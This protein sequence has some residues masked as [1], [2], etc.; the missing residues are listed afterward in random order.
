MIC[1]S[2]NMKQ[3]LVKNKDG[4]YSEVSPD[5][6]NRMSPL[7]NWIEI[8]EEAEE[9]YY[10]DGSDLDVPED[11][12]FYTKDLEATWSGSYWYDNTKCIYPTYQEIKTYVKDY[13]KLVW[14]RKYV[15]EQV[16]E[17]LNKF[18]GETSS[19]TPLKGYSEQKHDLKYE[20]FNPLDVQEG[21]GHYKSRG[22]QPLEYTQANNLNFQQGNVVKYITRHREKNG[23]EDLAKVVHY[24]L[25]EAYFVYGIEGSSELKDRILKMLGEC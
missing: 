2:N 8:P 17:N 18:L 10:F 16:K 19:S 6:V 21:G 22:I 11:L 20:T 23:V 15:D 7:D 3:Y 24:A 14:E 5:T 1:K 4:S 25:L 12:L 9:C 13:G